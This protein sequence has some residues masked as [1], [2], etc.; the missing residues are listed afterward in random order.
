VDP[1]GLMGARLFSPVTLGGLALANRIVVSP[2][3][4]YRARDGTAS[5]WHLVHLG[6]FA[7]SRAGMVVIE[8]TGVLPE[9][10]I[11][12]G[13]LGL[14]SD[15]N[16][17]AIAR[18]VALFKAVGPMPLAIQ[19]AHAGR[20]GSSALPWAGGHGLGEGEGGWPTVSSSPL[21]YDDRHPAPQALDE[22]GMERIER[23]FAAAA[24]RAARIGLDAV[25]LHAAHGYLLHQ[26][27]SPLVNRRRDDHGGC[28]AN[29][30]RFPLRVASALR[31]AWPA[32]RALGA[33]IN[34]PDGVE[35]GATIADTIAFAEGLKAIGYDYVCVS[36]GSLYGGQRFAAAPGYLL[37][38][39]EAV[40]RE[41]GVTTMG[42]GLIVDPFLA[43]AAVAGG[44]ADLVALARGFL[45]DPRWVWHA[46]ERLGVAMPF[47]PEYRGA[48][49]AHWAGAPHRALLARDPHR[50]A[51]GD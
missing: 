30:L 29:R 34:G 24:R 33:R 31:A 32:G 13:C 18:V 45:E 49:P 26:F 37:P 50:A 47:P 25:E 10:R 11:T 44:R 3:C 19:L 16:E 12:P 48:D 20:K 23:G 17:A 8:A 28:R 43:E 7:L 51:A 14:W 1:D 35:G 40:R 5:D 38:H 6:Q 21:P 4:Q 2:M 27:V 15:A 39:A 36:T 9:G 46:A 22:A 42:V 41:A